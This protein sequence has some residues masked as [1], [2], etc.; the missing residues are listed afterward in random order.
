MSDGER[1]GD[2][3]SEA[4]R[5]RRG[6]LVRESLRDRLRPAA[7]VARPPEPKPAPCLSIFDPHD[8][9]GRSPPPP[10]RPSEVRRS[11]SRPWVWI[12][13]VVFV[14]SVALALLAVRLLQLI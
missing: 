8:L 11:G 12:A 3:D 6:E 4:I 9:E 5:A 1:D 10:H 2:E 14:V 13:A 7:P